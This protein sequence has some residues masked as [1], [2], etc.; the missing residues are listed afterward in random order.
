MSCCMIAMERGS[1]HHAS[2]GGRA[3]HTTRPA[4]HMLLVQE[5]SEVREAIAK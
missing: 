5:I 3:R 4:R 1:Y 2:F